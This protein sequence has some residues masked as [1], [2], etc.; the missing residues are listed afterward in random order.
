MS[1]FCREGTSPAVSLGSTRCALVLAA[2]NLSGVGQE[3]ER[4]GSTLEGWRQRPGCSLDHLTFSIIT[5]HRYPE[6]CGHPGVDSDIEYILKG[7][8]MF[9]SSLST[10]EMF[11]PCCSQSIW[12]LQHHL[13]QEGESHEG[14]G[15]FVLKPW[16]SSSPGLI[17]NLWPGR[18]TVLVTTWPLCPQ[19]ISFPGSDSVGT[20]TFL[21]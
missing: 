13:T 6:T 10:L 11:M 15:S 9:K 21:T 5:K 16:N 19:G 14:T 20:H 17:L 7:L 3:W 18:N 1:C 4:G 2:W 12:K 8:F